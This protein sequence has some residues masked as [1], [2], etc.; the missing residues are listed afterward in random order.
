M[1]P[2]AVQELLANFNEQKALVVESSSFQKRKKRAKKRKIRKG[3][4][5]EKQ[6][7]EDIKVVKIILKIQVPPASTH[8]QA[9]I[10]VA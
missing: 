5:I 9:V 6:K 10:L 8:S 2:C 4:E 7:E 3:N 1:Y